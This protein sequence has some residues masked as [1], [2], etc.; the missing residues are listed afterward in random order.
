M[1]LIH[2]ER[3]ERRYIL[4]VTKNFKKEAYRCIVPERVQDDIIIPMP[5]TIDVTRAVN[6]V[7]TTLLVSHCYYT[8]RS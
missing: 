2:C 4:L 8:N 7:T 3:P 1:T 6:A 5:L